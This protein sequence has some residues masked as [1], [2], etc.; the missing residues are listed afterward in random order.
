MHR[1]H[2]ARLTLHRRSV[3]VS[4]PLRSHCS[5]LAHKPVRKPKAVLASLLSPLLHTERRWSSRAPLARLRSLASD[6][7]RTLLFACRLARSCSPSLSNGAAPLV[8]FKRPM[9]KYQLERQNAHTAPAPSQ[10]SCFW[11]RGAVPRAFSFQQQKNSGLLYSR[12]FWQAA[13]R[14]R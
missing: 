13:R 10:S 7:K 8:D 6:C 9:H 12:L 2:I 11:M 14:E 5:V 3:V 1:T 4:A